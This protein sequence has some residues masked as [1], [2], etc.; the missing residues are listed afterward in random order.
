[1]D[2]LHDFYIDKV[3][4]F[5]RE[6]SKSENPYGYLFSS[7]VNY[8]KDYRKKEARRRE[9]SPSPILEGSS[10]TVL[11]ILPSQDHE[12]LYLYL[13]KNVIDD[14]LEVVLN[15]SLGLIEIKDAWKPYI[16]EYLDTVRDERS[17]E[18]IEATMNY[19]IACYYAWE[20]VDMNNINLIA[21]KSTTKGRFHKFMRKIKQN[22]LYRT[23]SFGAYQ[24]DYVKFGNY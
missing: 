13:H 21:E 15:L 3:D 6:Y 5:D 23:S 7:L 22:A 14:Y 18:G 10:D 9:Y 16:K 24:K 12:Q 20:K 1:M 8:L 4:K 2:A 19:I 11:D 17:E